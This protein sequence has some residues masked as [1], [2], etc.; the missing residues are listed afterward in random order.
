M[1]DTRLNDAMAEANRSLRA[2]QA[3]LRALDAAD[4]DD[5]LHRI[6]L[7]LR[8]AYLIVDAIA[9]YLVLQRAPVYD[10]YSP[11]EAMRQYSAEFR[12]VKSDGLDSVHGDRAKTMQCLKLLR[13]NV[14]LQHGASLMLALLLEEGEPRIHFGVSGD[15][16]LRNT[17]R[18]EPLFEIPFE[19]LERFWAAATN[20]GAIESAGGELVL[21]L[22]GDEP[23]RPLAGDVNRAAETMGRAARRL[24]A[25]RGASGMHEPGLV[26][27]EESLKLYRDSVDKALA[28]V[29]DASR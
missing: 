8:D 9:R 16:E 5:V 24:M 12:A 20:G 26:G 14:N 28:F 22:D 3:E 25:W 27:A 19:E 13:E 23:I 10:D 4:A 15:G 1:I 29:E 17:L 21:Y 6:D 11:I 2:I 7:K 18:I